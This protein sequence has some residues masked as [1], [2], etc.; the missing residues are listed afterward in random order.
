MASKKKPKKESST[1]EDPKSPF[2]KLHV[3]VT[4]E[5]IDNGMQGDPERCPVA[6]ALKA[7]APKTAWKVCQTYAH[8]PANGHDYDFVLRVTMAIKQYDEGRGMAPMGF[9]LMRFTWT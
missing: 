6:L 8:D 1:T 9:D 2:R 5:H 7:A 4:Q 3:E